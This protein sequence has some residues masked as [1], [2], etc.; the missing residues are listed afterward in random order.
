ML[1]ALG[2]EK[3]MEMN[4]MQRKFF[5]V[6]TILTFG[7]YNGDT[8]QE[9]FEKDCQYIVWMYENFT[10]VDWSDDAEKLVTEAMDVMSMDKRSSELDDYYRDVYGN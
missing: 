1:I 5:D 10:D 2:L 4:D 9:I 7:I 6:D 3:I 8:V